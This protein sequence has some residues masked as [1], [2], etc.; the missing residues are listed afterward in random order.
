MSVFGTDKLSGSNSLSP[1]AWWELIAYIG[2]IW[3]VLSQ[4]I[5]GPLVRRYVTE[6]KMIKNVSIE[7]FHKR[8]I[9]LPIRKAKA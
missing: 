6:K 3:Y 4:V 1:A 5:F 2:G 8:Q 9:P 7:I